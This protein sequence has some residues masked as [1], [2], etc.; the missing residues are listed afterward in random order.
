MHRRRRAL[1]KDPVGRAADAFLAAG[2]SDEAL[3]FVVIGRQLV[4]GNGPV[5][6]QTVASV[7]R[8]IIIGEAQRDATEVIGSSADHARAEP[9]E[10]RPGRDRVWFS[11]KF[12]AP[13]CSREI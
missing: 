7:G 8:K 13:R 6:S 2:D 4:V 10:L 1:L 9:L 11:W 12:P 3:G 5:R